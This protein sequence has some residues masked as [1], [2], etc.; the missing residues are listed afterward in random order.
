MVL[1]ASKCVKQKYKIVKNPTIN[2]RKIAAGR[3]WGKKKKI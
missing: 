3:K 1:K 2:N